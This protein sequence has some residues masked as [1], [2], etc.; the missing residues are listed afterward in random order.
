[1]RRAAEVIGIPERQ[2][3][4]NQDRPRVY[5]PRVE[6]ARVD[7]GEPPGAW[8]ERAPQ[9]DDD[10]QRCAR[11]EDENRSSHAAREE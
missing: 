4:I 2:V 8:I 1:M 9:H 3:S 5:L 11:Q 10:E 7:S 6:V